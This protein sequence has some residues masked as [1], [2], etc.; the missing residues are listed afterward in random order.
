MS[1]LK[2]IIS[3]LVLSLIVAVIVLVFIRRK[4]NAREV[5]IRYPFNNAIFP[6][7]FPA[8]SFEWKSEKKTSSPWEVS[9]V[10]RNKKYSIIATTAGTSWTPEESKWDSLKRLSD[11]DR[12]YFTL[13]R[14]GE[15]KPLRKIAISISHDTVGAPILYRQMPIPFVIAERTLDSMNFMLINLGSSKKPHVA[16]SGF[17]VCGNCHSFSADGRNIGL[18]LDAGLRDK[19]GYFISPIKDTILFNPAN[20]MSWSKIE[21]RRTFGLFSKMSPDGRYIVTTVKDR[22]V[23]KNFPV[24]PVEN[25]IFSQL[26]FPVNGHLAVYDRQTNILRE[27]PG[28]NLE[29]YVQSNAIWTPDGKNIIFSRAEALPRDS[30]IYQINVQDADLINKYVKREKTLKFNLYIIPFNDG[31]GG[32]AVP[33]KGASNNGKSNYFPAVSPDGKWL[34]FCQ[35]ETFMLLMP[36]SRLFIVPVGGGKARMLHSN[37][38]SMNSW[39]AWSP[40]SKWLVFASKGMSLYTDMFLTHIDE[41]GNDGIPVL[42]E[43][44]RVPYK[45]I[46]YPEFVNRKPDDTF[47]MDYDYVELAHIKRAIKS[48]DF[49]KAKALFHKLEAQQPFLFAEDC[50]E[51][52]DMLKTIGMEE[53]SKKYAE[54]AKHTI[55]SDLFNKQ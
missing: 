31:N 51:L 24:N 4:D 49:E 32:E 38:Y 33:I 44:A 26:F 29:E 16:M 15:S 17:T 46:N 41:K 55:N 30:D 18:D 35:A 54:Q 48:N 13:K 10:T 37:L 40:N 47:V 27:L 50:V 9:L 20:Y 45:V 11:F 7:E 22:V 21:K 28:A 43:K 25:I 23:M 2:V 1:K 39:H 34:V 6:P 52:S 42:V 8:P 12:I 36:D 3:A 5:L 19:G 14:S 53:E